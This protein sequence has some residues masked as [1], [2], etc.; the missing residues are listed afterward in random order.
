M[1]EVFHK[2]DLRAQ[3]KVVVQLEMGYV[4]ALLITGPV[5]LALQPSGL[6]LI[7]LFFV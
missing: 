3:W 4:F 7:T 2:H 5:S 6:Y 1:L